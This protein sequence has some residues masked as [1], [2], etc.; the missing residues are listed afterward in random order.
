MLASI[1]SPSNPYL[2][3]GPIHLRYYGLLIA[4]GVVVATRIAAVRWTAKG[5][6]PEEVMNVVVVTVI[7]GIIGA[8]L[9]HVITDYQRFEHDWLRAFEIWKGGLSIWGA[10]IFGALAVAVMCRV[11]HYDTLGMMD[12]MAP[13]VAVAQAI[14]RFGNWFN[15]ELFGRPTTL[16]WGLQIDPDNPDA[17]PGAQAYHPTFLYEAI[18]NLVGCA[19]LLWLSAR[20]RF[21]P[22]AL[23]A[24]Y[25][26]WYC[27]FRTYEETL[28]I[29]PAHTFLGQRVNFWVSIVL[30]VVSVAFFIWWQFFRR[31]ED[32]EQPATKLPPAPE[33]PAMAIPRGRVRSGR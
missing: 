31:S 6:D 30:F 3:L 32:Q 29:D 23:F 18:W 9:Y 24:L 14:G 21:R 16:P 7:A 2:D 10:V 28:R 25:V 19:L 15:Q 33:G 1:P 11:R 22:P 27:A 26:A 8:R 20:Y 12:A 5:H 13:G 17:V 4:L